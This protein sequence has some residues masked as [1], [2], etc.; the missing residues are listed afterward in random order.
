MGRH[1]RHRQDSTGA[2]G[3]GGCQAEARVS[4]YQRWT[5][6]PDSGRYAVHTAP[7]GPKL[8]GGGRHAHPTRA[9]GR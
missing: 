8:F 1:R 6:G 9:V 3:V 5:V 4:T 7:K 2:L